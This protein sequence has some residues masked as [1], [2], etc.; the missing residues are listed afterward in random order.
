[1]NKMT[2]NTMRATLFATACLCI[3]PIIC[4]IYGIIQD[5]SSIA[6]VGVIGI[7]I[8]FIISMFIQAHQLRKTHKTHKTHKT[9]K[10]I[11]K[12]YINSVTVANYSEILEEDTHH[13]CINNTFE[14]CNTGAPKD[15][16]VITKIIL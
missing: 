13:I 4:L 5:S 16:V 10:C 9:Q 11:S 7:F 8:T 1:M 15:N 2:H 3:L 14:K 6:I 12:N